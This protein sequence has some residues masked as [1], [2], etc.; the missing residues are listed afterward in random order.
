MKYL[1]WLNIIVILTFLSACSSGAIPIASAST[2]TPLPPPIVNVTSAPNPEIALGNYL[3]AYQTD[4]YNTMY[5]MLSKVT[6]DAIPLDDFAKRNR[7]AL[8]TMS[9]GSFD[10]EV[11]SSLVNPYSAEIA[12][13]VTY[14]TA[15]VGDLQRD[16]IARFVLDNN[17]WKLQWDD[18]LILPEMAGGNILRMD[19]SIPARGNIYDR[20]GDPLAAQSDVYAFS[21]IPGNVT[22]ES[23]GILVSEVWRLCG[24][25]QEVLSEQ[26]I[27][28]PDFFPIPLCEAS[29]Q[30]SQRIRSIYPSGLEW[31]P[32]NSRYYF[33]Q[34]VGSNVVGYT[35]PIFAEDLEKYLRLGRYREIGR[36]LPK[37]ETWRHAVRD[38][39]HHGRY[40]HTYR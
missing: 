40:R 20:N 11:R 2:D 27:N 14:H 21:I 31:T 24:I 18:S 33:E 29:N 17:E 39:S 38:Q 10:Y 26:I 7:D 15:L 34:G 9:A 28:T 30:E 23:F 22:D 13:S 12:Y 35:Q 25:D 19:Y 37:R 5:G 4:D 16:I 3:M 36:R 8:N 6:Q 32:Y 1:R